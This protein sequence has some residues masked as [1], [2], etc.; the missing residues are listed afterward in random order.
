MS[1]INNKS[2]KGTKTPQKLPF[3]LVPKK[4]KTEKREREEIAE[5]RH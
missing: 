3:T 4:T 2:G 5:G 1:V